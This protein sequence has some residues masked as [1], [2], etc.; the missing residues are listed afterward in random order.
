LSA[1]IN[2]IVLSPEI[3]AGLAKLNATPKIGSPEDFAKFMAME[4]KKWT[5]V[6]NAAGIK[7]E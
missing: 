3:E 6:A 4:T 5:G 7:A 2:A 1:A